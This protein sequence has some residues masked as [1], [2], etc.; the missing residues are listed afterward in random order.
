MGFTMIPVHDTGDHQFV[1]DFI[2]HEFIHKS[3]NI[4][5]FNPFQDNMIF[6]IPDG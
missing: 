5:R 2:Q 1:I 6:R 3:G 4:A